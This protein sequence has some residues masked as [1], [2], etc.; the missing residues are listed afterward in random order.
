MIDP[1]KIHLSELETELVNN[2]E[3]IFRKQK[4][5]EKLYYLFGE[6]HTR[7]REI[8]AKNHG[9]LPLIF[10][11]TLS[12]LFRNFIYFKRNCTLLSWRI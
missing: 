6:L 8:V 12:W 1:A 10:Q 4:I 7:Y 9:E 3:W 2:T 5:T 11:K